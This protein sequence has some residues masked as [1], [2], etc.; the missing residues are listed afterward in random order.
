LFP[1][2]YRELGEQVWKVEIEEGDRPKLIVNCEIPAIS[3]KLHQ[4]VILQAL[5][6]PAAFRIV[7]EKLAQNPIEDDDEEPGW[8]TEWLEFCK[9]SLGIHEDPTI[10]E[11]E[12]KQE[13]VDTDIF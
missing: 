5:V 10:L 12:Q 13:W 4:H 3:S 6:F 1:V 9:Q 8:K 2:V 11:T 7:L